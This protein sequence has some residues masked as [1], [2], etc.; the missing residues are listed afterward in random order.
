MFFR[1]HFD[2]IFISIAFLI[3]IALMVI[4]FFNGAPFWQIITEMTF[5]CT[6]I[7]VTLLILYWWC[8]KRPAKKFNQ[9]P[10]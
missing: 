9:N 7:A 10:K 3:V 5:I 4:R 1:K 6:Q 2:T 8:V